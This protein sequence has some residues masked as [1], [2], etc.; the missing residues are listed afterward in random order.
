L[1]ARISRALQA[2][3]RWL[4]GRKTYLGLIAGTVYACLC[5]AGL[6]DSNDLVWT[7]IAVWTGFAFRSAVS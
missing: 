5:I 6:T 4:K 3:R 7:I 2:A 1:R